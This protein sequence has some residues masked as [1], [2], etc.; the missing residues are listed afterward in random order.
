MLEK[1][2]LTGKRVKLVP[3][4]Q[5][6]VQGLFAAGNDP[7]IWTYLPSKMNALEHM[8]E[9]VLEALDAQEN[10]LQLPFT[11]M[12]V[13]TNEIIGSTRFLNL[14]LP[15]KNLEIGWTWYSPKVWRTH[16]NT[17][18]K[19]LL[20]QYGFEEL[21]LVRVQFRADA[22]NE[23]SNKAILRIGAKHE[24]TLRK[25]RILHNGFIRDTQQYS[26]IEAEWPGVKASLE[27]KLQRA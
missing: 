16:V 26:I 20:L 22:R 23:R 8:N 9:L 21:G 5:A 4:E 3:L 15:N 24:G 11:I 10:G 18:C 27:A 2:A 12:D 14:S 17:E 13:Q 6:H 19:Y 1:V 7:Q 25:D